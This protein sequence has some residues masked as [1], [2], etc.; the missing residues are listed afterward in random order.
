MPS[1]FTVVTE[2]VN[3]VNLETEIREFRSQAPEGCYGEIIKLG[4]NQRKEA[5]SRKFY[6]R[7]AD[8]F[9]PSVLKIFVGGRD[10]GR[11]L[12]PHHFI[13]YSKIVFQLD[14]NEELI[15]TAV[16]DASFFL[17]RLKGLRFLM[18]RNNCEGMPEE[19]ID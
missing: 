3:M 12:T 18:G 1:P 15:I 2:L 5:S 4:P 6:Q 10:T 19:E 9:R 7:A 14:G 8:S 16:R 17:Y 13:Y 11:V